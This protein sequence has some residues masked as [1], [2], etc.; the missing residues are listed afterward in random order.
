DR[1]PGHHAEVLLDSPA[2]HVRGGGDQHRLLPLLR[3]GIHA[4]EIPPARP[5]GHTT[6]SAVAS[7]NPFPRPAAPAGSAPRKGYT[8]RRRVCGRPRVLSGK[9][10]QRLHQPPKAG[11]IRTQTGGT[12]PCGRWDGLARRTPGSRGR[13]PTRARAFG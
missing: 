13:G 6:P 8:A 1:F 10:T 9:R 11:T 12:A 2:F 7:A 5:C 4:S 3:L